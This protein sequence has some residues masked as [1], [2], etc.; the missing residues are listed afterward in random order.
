MIFKP[1]LQ[2]LPTFL[3]G[4]LVGALSTLA[5][6]VLLTEEKLPSPTT[7]NERP[8]LSPFISSARNESIPPAAPQS[9]RKQTTSLNPAILESPSVPASKQSVERLLAGLFKNEKA[10]GSNEFKDLAYLVRNDKRIAAQI[11]SRIE[12]S[13]SYDE[14]M[15]LV[16]LLASDNSPETLDYATTLI[17]SMEPEMQGLGYE[18]LSSMDNKGHSTELKTA[19]LD[20]SLYESNPDTLSDIIYHLGKAEL[21]EAMKSEAVESLQHLMSYSEDSAVTAR[22]IDGLSRLGDQDSIYYA[23]LEH[24]NHPD[25]TVKVSAINALYS[26]DK[27]MLNQSIIESLQDLSNS[28]EES[29]TARDYA[30]NFLESYQSTE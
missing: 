8:P 20:A 14:T 4:A 6:T 23:V 27:S 17:E 28:Q 16:A 25:N 19:L 13:S 24:L 9:P 5:L 10:Y 1:S 22:A 7:I 11:R 21:N 2:K 3:F 26:L 18:L 12:E 30:A 15:T 29:E